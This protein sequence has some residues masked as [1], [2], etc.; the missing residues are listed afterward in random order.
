[1]KTIIAMN[2]VNTLDREIATF[3]M[4]HA[5]VLPR[6]NQY[7]LHQVAEVINVVMEVNPKADFKRVLKV[8][9]AQIENYFALKREY[10]YECAC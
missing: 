2:T 3:I 5:R 10:E 8:A 9:E 1:M 4:K 6:L 7:P